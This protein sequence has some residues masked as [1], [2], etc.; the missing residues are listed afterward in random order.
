MKR[1]LKMCL[2]LIMLLTVSFVVLFIDIEAGKR[3]D[4]KAC[5]TLQPAQ[6]ADAVIQDVIWPENKAFAK[7]QLTANNVQVNMRDIQLGSLTVL[8]PFHITKDPNRQ[9]F[10]M[11]RCSVLTN[12]E[13]ASD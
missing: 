3:A 8:V 10:G 1:V 6:V 11:L 12:V 13:Y 7:F 9:Y 4:L 5:K 2:G